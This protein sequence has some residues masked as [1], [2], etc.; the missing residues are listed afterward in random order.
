MMHSAHLF[1]DSGQCEDLLVGDGG[2]E[3]DCVF[4]VSIFI[5]Q[6]FYLSQRYTILFEAKLFRVIVMKLYK[7]SVI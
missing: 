2:G 1:G 7:S 6:S 3:K 5:F 4:H